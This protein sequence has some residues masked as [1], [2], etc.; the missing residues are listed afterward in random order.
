MI[1]NNLLFVCL[2]FF[3]PFLNKWHQNFGLISS[4]LWKCNSFAGQ[5]W[6]SHVPHAEVW[7]FQQPLWTAVL[8]GSEK[9]KGSF[10]GASSYCK[11]CHIQM[12][13]LGRMVGP[14]TQPLGPHIRACHFS[15][16]A[17]K[18]KIFLSCHKP[19]WKLNSLCI[20]IAL[21]LCRR[22]WFSQQYYAENQNFTKL[23]WFQ[24]CCWGWAALT[25]YIWLVCISWLAGH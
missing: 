5:W 1:K 13:L 21:W 9:E 24:G 7:Y 10:F 18:G 19:L 2:G 4:I 12:L 17:D 6:K 15:Y 25:W 23:W 14:L 20:S 8:T 3:F 22:H 16:C 11:L